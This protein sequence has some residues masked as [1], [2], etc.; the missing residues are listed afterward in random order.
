[1]VVHSYTSGSHAV[2]P[3]SHELTSCYFWRVSTH[4]HRRY[5][6]VSSFH[7][8]NSSALSRSFCVFF[9]LSRVFE[10]NQKRGITTYTFFFLTFIAVVVR[11]G[12]FLQ[13]S[14]INSTLLIICHFA[15]FVDIIISHQSPEPAPLTF[16]EVVSITKLLTFLSGFSS[17][18][19]EARQ[20]LREY[21]FERIWDWWDWAN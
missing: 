14:V 8:W 5:L 20:R 12:Y 15:Y 1:M 2:E 16:V 4:H 19:Y 11:G 3:V 18:S 21:N 10:W 13:K 9:L 6:T 17:S 7:F